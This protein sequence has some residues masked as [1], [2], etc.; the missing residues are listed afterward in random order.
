MPS[1]IR[2]VLWL[3]FIVGP[4]LFVLGNA[5]PGRGV[6]SLDGLYFYVTQAFGQRNGRI[7]FIGAWLLLSAALLWRFEFGPRKNVDPGPPAD[8]HD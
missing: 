7:V 3:L 4:I 2:S 5:E 6:D 8:L 1:A